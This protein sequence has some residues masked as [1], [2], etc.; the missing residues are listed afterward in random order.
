MKFLPVNFS[1]FWV[2]A[3]LIVSYSFCQAQFITTWKTDNTSTSNNDQITIPGTG[4]YSIAWEEVGNAANN[5][6]DAGSGTTTLTF[7]SAGTYQISI[8]GGLTRI[9]FNYSGDRQK[10]LTIEQWGDIAWTSLEAAFAGCTNLTY[11]ASD[12]PDLSSVTSL[13]DMFSYCDNF[14][15]AIGNWDVS[16]IT[17]MS[18]MFLSADA[19]NQ[20][21]SSWDVSSVTDMSYMF[22]YASDFNQNIGSWNVSK[23]NYM[24][25]MFSGAYDFNQNI[26]SWNVSGVYSF[27]D[28]FSFATNFNQDISSW[29]VSSAWSLDRMFEY[30]YDFNQNLNSWDVSG[31]SSFYSMFSGASSF[32]QPLNSW[33]VS[34]ANNMSYMFDGASAFNQNL[35]AWNVSNVD[36]MNNMFDGASA[37]NQDLSTWDVSDVDDM[38]EMLRYASSFNQ[39]LASWNISSVDDMTNMLSNSGLSQLNYDA[40]LIAWDALSVTSGVTVGASGL[41]YCDAGETARNDLISNDS[42]SFSGDSKDCS[43]FPVELL[44]FTAQAETF[45]VRLDWQTAQEINNQFFTIER[46]PDQSHWETITTLSGAG[47]SHTPHRYMARDEMPLVGQA[48][49][50]LKQTDFD[51]NFSYSEIERVK[52]SLNENIQFRIFPNPTSDLVTLIGTSTIGAEQITVYDLMG[53]ELQNQLQI[54]TLSDTWIRIDLRALPA[55]TYFLQP[56]RFTKKTL[57]L[58]LQ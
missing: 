51:G 42:W 29:N 9:Y 52:F 41:E 39:S 40:T 1:T 19:F 31:I 34:S 38:D 58:Q 21:L 50:R 18:S 15:G 26:G 11:N 48:Y 35:S 23:V 16:T 28:M 22:A 6:T 7:P 46:S 57:R 44:S 55:G 8:T 36:Y 12:A 10:L 27:S 17:D 4:S 54:E 33:D 37:F 49:Y 25:R 5:G 20:D 30:A 14:N 53:R 56:S 3:A 43:T 24:Y 32:N 13:K 2:F 45:S 47:T